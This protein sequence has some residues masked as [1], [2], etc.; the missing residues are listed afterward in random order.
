MAFIEGPIAEDPETGN[1]N[2]T[3]PST[4]NQETTMWLTTTFGFFSIVQKDGD[5]HLTVRAR[6]R[7]D[8]DELRTRYLPELSKT[9]ALDRT[10]YRYRAT[11]P[12]A[13]L[14]KAMAAIVADITYDNFKA[15]VELRQGQD[16]ELVY[17]RVWGVLHDD[18]PKLDVLGARTR[19]GRTSK[20]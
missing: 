7:A 6:V 20:R 2:P 5:K 10:D 14:A 1:A 19:V 18:L 13:A 16:R 4:H 12:G 15:E 3:H 8:L 17:S 9:V 11:V